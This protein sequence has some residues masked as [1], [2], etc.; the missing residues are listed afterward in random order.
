MGR[1]AA[2]AVVVA[3]T[4]ALGAPAAD[5][6]SKP[7]SKGGSV[8]Q[9]DIQTCIGANGSSPKEQVPA[10]SKVIA[11]GKVK[12]PYEGDYYAMRGAALYKL[13]A[14]DKAL[15]D[16]NKAI[17]IRPKPEMYFE[18]AL[19]HMAKQDVEAA[20]S[21][22]A[23]VMKLK[24]AFAPSYFMR[25]LISYDAGEYAEAVKHFDG[26]VQRL[27]AYYQAIY[28]RGVAKKRAG[29]ES[30]G[31]KDIKEARGMSARI[32]AEMEKLGLKL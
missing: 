20:K 4:V 28:A 6:K 11:S 27:P 32:D 3:A 21:D 31:E 9:Q 23:Q 15:E 25:G 13:R 8:T 16:Y 18:R 1:L 26:A 29:D 24:P 10:C 19:V 14:F 5:A 12:H 22:L 17:T 7:K 2:I 30:G